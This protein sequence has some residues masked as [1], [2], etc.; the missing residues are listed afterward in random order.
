MKGEIFNLFEEFIVQNWGTDV[1]EEIYESIHTNLQTK[2]PFVGPGTYPDSDFFTIVSKAVEK[3]NVSL[4]DGIHLFGKFCLPKLI[5]KMPQY[6]EKYTHPK[7]FLLTIHDVIHV[8]VK[9]VYK[10]A[11]PPDFIY[12]DPAPDKLIMIYKS[13]RKLYDF[14]EGLLDGVSE[15]F[16]MPI[17]YTRKIISLDGSEACEFELSFG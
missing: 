10:D 5:A 7:A 13:K 2:D 8:E 9:K 11:T 17:T 16:K 14:V 15:H 12:R 6:V 4:N 1:F 3:L